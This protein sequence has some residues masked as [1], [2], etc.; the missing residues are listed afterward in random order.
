MLSLL[1]Q[2]ILVLK[3]ILN[4]GGFSKIAKLDVNF[5]QNDKL[6]N[7]TSILKEDIAL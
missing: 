4:N 1:K 2:K 6:S 3:I 7:M 5:Q